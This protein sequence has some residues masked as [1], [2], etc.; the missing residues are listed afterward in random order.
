ME[1]MFIIAVWRLYRILQC[2]ISIALISCLVSWIYN[3][4]IVPARGTSSYYVAANN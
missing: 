1:T 2:H 4:S 3:S